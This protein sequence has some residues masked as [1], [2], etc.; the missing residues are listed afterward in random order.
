MLKT[1]VG[2]V[3]KP[4]VLSLT[5]LFI[6]VLSLG[7]ALLPNAHGETETGAKPPPP[8]WSVNGRWDTVNAFA[9]PVIASHV[10]VLPNGKVLAWGPRYEETDTKIQIWDPT[11]PCPTPTPGQ[12]PVCVQQTPVPAEF[13]DLY[14]T[15]HSFL[16]NGKLLVT[17]GTNH[18]ATPTPSGAPPLGINKAALYDHKS[19]TWTPLPNMNST[20]W[21]PTN[22]TLSDGSALVWGGVDGAAYEQTN[23]TPQVLEKQGSGYIWRDLDLKSPDSSFRYYSWLNMLSSGKA[24][25]TVGVDGTSYLMTPGKGYRYPNDSVLKFPVDP[26]NPKL[27]GTLKGGVRDAGSQIV[28]DKDRMVAIGG[29]FDLP[30]NTVEMIHL[31]AS[32]PQWTKVG[33]LRV[34]RRHHNSTIL[35]DGKVL[36]T[37][38]NKGDGFNNSCPENAVKEAEMWDPYSTSMDDETE[39]WRQLAPATQI[40]TYHSSA[41]L[42]PDGR[43]FTGGTTW[44]DPNGHPTFPPVNTDTCTEPSANNFV[45]EIFSPPYLFNAD[46]TDATRPEI[47]SGPTEELAFGQSYQYT[48]SNGGS[49]PTVSLVR[50]P[51]VT[52]S[53]N[54]N[55]GFLRMT[56]TLV[57]SPSPAPPA[58]ASV[59]SVTMPPRN[60]LVPGHYMMFFLTSGGTVKVPSKARIIQICNTGQCT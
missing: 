32:N 45:I 51:S 11:T 31:D 17:G 55:Q 15:G 2:R 40:R 24:L 59:Y 37:G 7:S 50:L 4:T 57:T 34:G 41:V 20:R 58:G 8:D 1:L 25:L 13:G 19:G 16:P 44:L 26:T 6:L 39:E 27:D 60:E 29:G 53:F 30:K 46:G 33:H 47:L 12:L 49:N 52:H 38:G 54:Q 21:Y 22:M 56:P 14:C 5:S 23:R 28:F 18:G 43:V 35:P 3:N 36:V 48:V 10:S 42:L 9:S